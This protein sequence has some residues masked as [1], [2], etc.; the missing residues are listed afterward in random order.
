MM[1]K[2]RKLGNH[3]LERLPRYHVGTQKLTLRFDNQEYGDIV[4]IP[5]DSDCAGSEEPYSTHAGLEFHGGYL[6][7]S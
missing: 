5:V 7:D 6:V 3:R 1:T 4:R 2:S